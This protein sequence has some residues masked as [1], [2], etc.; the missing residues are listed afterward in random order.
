MRSLLLILLLS[1][2]LYNCT[3]CG[4]QQ[5]PAASLQMSGQVSRL[6]SLQAVGTLDPDYFK[7]QVGYEIRDV[8]Y[9]TLPLSLHADSTTYIFDFQDR[10]DTLTI[11][12]KRE[13]Y[14][15]D[16]C[17]FVMDLAKPS[18]GSHQKSTFSRVNVSYFPYVISHRKV[19]FEHHITG[20]GIHV[21]L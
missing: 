10:M 6:R 11:Y 5:E 15:K 13:F 14:Y 7:S 18:S 1:P 9:F 21:E 4:P 20:I 2:A 8:T 12:Y 19:I 3:Y 16:N 17:G